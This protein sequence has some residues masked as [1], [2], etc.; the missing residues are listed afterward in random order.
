MRCFLNNIT[1]SRRSKN[2]IVDLT[3]TIFGDSV[4]TQYKEMLHSMVELHTSVRKLTFVEDCA[5]QSRIET[6]E[7]MEAAI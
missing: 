4:I 7:T 5:N 2:E 6:D 1:V 3:S